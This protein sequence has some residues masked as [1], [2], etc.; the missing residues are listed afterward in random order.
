MITKEIMLKT[1]YDNLIRDLT[2]KNKYKN[3]SVL[4]SLL[5]VK[6]NVRYKIF[7]DS[8]QQIDDLDLANALINDKLIRA[9]E[10]DN[11]YTLTALGLWEVEN[12]KYPLMK[13]LD[14]FDDKYFNISG[15]AK[16]IIDK[17]KIILLSLISLRS[18]SL[19]YA[20][21]LKKNNNVLNNLKIVLDDICELLIEIGEIKENYRKQLYGKKGNEH[22]V[23]NV[24]R[25]TDSL[26]KKT[27]AIYTTVN[28]QKYFLNIPNN[29]EAMEKYLILLFGKI[30]ENKVNLTNRS[31]N[32]ILRKIKNI[33]YNFSPKVFLD[34]T[35][36]F[37]CYSYDKI[38]INALNKMFMGDN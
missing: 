4:E 37:V 14:F 9:Y 31:V 17:E 12:E 23:S 34:E 5:M 8:S 22:I 27:H 26:P 38:I 33:A 2:I 21:D 19:K 16:Q 3:Q 18:F 13:L 24:F 32:I 10:D 11:K 6:S 1:M 29:D 20:I 15:H 25:H 7:K 30:F 28:P 35:N 36:E